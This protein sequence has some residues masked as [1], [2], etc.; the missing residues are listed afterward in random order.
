VKLSWIFV[1]LLLVVVAVFSAQNAGVITVHFFAWQIAMS[2]ALVIQLAALLGALA[3]L[4]IGLFS[5][6]KPSPTP[7]AKS[8][9]RAP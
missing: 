7:P 8:P 1:I 4:T 2:G 5:R 9:A 3:G 6:R